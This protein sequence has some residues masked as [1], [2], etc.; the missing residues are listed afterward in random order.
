MRTDTYTLIFLIANGYDDLIS[1]S[2]VKNAGSA[3]SHELTPNNLKC[4]SLRFEFCAL[5]GL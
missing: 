1:A 3:P 4:G 2:Q 5:A